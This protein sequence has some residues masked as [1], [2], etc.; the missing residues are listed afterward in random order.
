[1]KY[2]SPIWLSQSRICLS[3]NL[4]QYSQNTKKLVGENHLIQMLISEQID[5]KFLFHLLRHQHLDEMIL[6]SFEDVQTKPF[7]FTFI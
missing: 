1:M 4:P 3:I 5:L 7:I 6:A 2:L